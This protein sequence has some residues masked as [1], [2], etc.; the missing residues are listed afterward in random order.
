MKNL[1]VIIDVNSNNSG[2][3]L[4]A[5][6]FCSGMAAAGIYLSIYLSKN[7]LQT[8]SENSDEPEFVQLLNSSIETL[9]KENCRFLIPEGSNA[10][11]LNI[12]DRSDKIEI[13][14]L[15]EVSLKCDYLLR[16]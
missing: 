11:F 12:A 9:K 5:M 16:F 3:I 15:A 7:S 1:F 10:D 14:Q 2:L 13:K 4:E 8:I 6:R